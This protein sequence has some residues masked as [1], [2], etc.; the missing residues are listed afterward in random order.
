MKDKTESSQT[1][2]IN[3]YNE[4]AKE[5]TSKLSELKYNIANIN[6]T[7]ELS[8]IAEKESLPDIILTSSDCI[9]DLEK[10]N[11]TKNNLLSQISHDLRSPI[12]TIK[13]MLELLEQK[14]ISADSP[15]Y[16][17]ILKDLVNTST[18]VFALLENLLYW[19]RI[20]F[21][22]VSYVPSNQNLKSLT[23]KAV[24]ELKR[25]IDEKKLHINININ[26]KTTVCG[27]EF[28]IHIILKNLISNGC[29]YSA[30]NSEIIID[31]E[32]S[33][34]KISIIIKDNGIGMSEENIKKTMDPDSLFHTSGTNGEQGNGMGLKICYNLTTINK[35]TLRIISKE[36]EGTTAILTLPAGKE[37]VK[38]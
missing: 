30:E 37:T 20:Q 32:K 2:I 27:D 35:G 29:K 19:S 17:N 22:T 26:S 23:Q 25:F 12:G 9:F 5:I 14:V 33:N 7:E 31:E 18:D 34:N 16:D 28:L 4:R 10:S 15:D 8:S 13:M 21:K 11:K 1:V 3:H 24:S 36:K 38:E 6:D